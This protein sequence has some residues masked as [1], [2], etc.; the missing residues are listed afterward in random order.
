MKLH[1]GSLTALLQGNPLHS[2]GLFT[3]PALPH[4]RLLDISSTSLTQ[5]SGNTFKR[6]KFLEVL[7]LK[8]K[9]GG[10]LRFDW[11]QKGVVQ[12]S[13]FHFYFI[14]WSWVHLS[15]YNILIITSF[16]DV[17]IQSPCQDNRLSWVGVSVFSPL[18]RLKSLQLGANPWACDCRL[19]P[20]WTWL[21]DRALL[22]FLPR[23]HQS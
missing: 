10:T 5:I 8:V 23:Q 4:L 3:F 13:F 7:N 21:R 20:L 6:L 2:L 1:E 15:T 17:S 19:A 12:Q 16:A 14:D 9:L 18:R 11:E 22:R